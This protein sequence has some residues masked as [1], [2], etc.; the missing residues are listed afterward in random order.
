MMLKLK[1][2]QL[3]GKDDMLNGIY[4]YHPSVESIQ[5]YANYFCKDLELSPINDKMIS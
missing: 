5:K 3:K 4:Y 2:A 1:L